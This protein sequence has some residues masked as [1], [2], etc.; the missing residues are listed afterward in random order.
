[1]KRGWEIKRLRELFTISP[2]KKEA[3]ERLNKDDLISFVPMNCLNIQDKQLTLKFTKKLEQA[4]KSYTYFSDNDVLLAKIT[5]CFENGK[6][7]IAKNLQNGIGFGSSEFIVFRSNGKVIPEYLFY[8]LSQES[9]REEGKGRMAGA[10]GHKRV[11]KEF[12]E[13]YTLPFPS[14][15]EQKRIVKI[16]DKAFAAIDKAKENAE[17]NLANCNE[18]F[19]SYLKSIFSN[20]GEDWEEKRLGEVC[21]V[22]DGTHDS[23]KYVEFGIPFI[24]QKNILVDGLNFNNIKYIKEEDHI[25]YY[26]R[27]NVMYNDI[28][29]SMIG[30]NR[31]LSCIVDDSRI[32]SIKNVGL[33]KY[34]KILNP[35]Y[36]LYYLKS[37][38]AKEYVEKCSKGSAQ[39]FIGLGALRDFPIRYLPLSKQM[40]YVNNLNK[41]NTTIE[42]IKNSLYMKKNIF[43]EL[44]Q[45]IFRKIFD[46][47]L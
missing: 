35:N 42:K 31:G 44:K 7:G 29:I 24:T 36:L 28:L 3:L 34:N 4:Y 43:N 16:L 13:N 10:V 12:I 25:K 9:F 45:S 19:D 14:L 23:P 30:A 40:K 18:L 11:S 33:I 1:M 38:L 5:P 47:E 27:S 22:R 20:P 21:E 46:G 37:P 15:P 32:F 2:P 26:K 8:F 17:K 41:I 6:V 39:G